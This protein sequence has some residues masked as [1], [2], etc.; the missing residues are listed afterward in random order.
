MSQE[1]QERIIAAA[2]T[3]AQLQFFASFLPLIN[4]MHDFIPTRSSPVEPVSLTDTHW[5][6]L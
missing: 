6:K 2:Q 3:D 4:R 5:F 1:A